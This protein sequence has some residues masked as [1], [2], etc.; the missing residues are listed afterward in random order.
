MVEAKGLARDRCSRRQVKGTH[1][2]LQ[3]GRLRDGVLHFGLRFNPE[4]SAFSPGTP[5]RCL[6]PSYHLSSDWNWLMIASETFNLRRVL[7]DLMVELP[8]MWVV[9][10]SGQDNVSRFEPRPTLAIGILRVEAWPRSVT[11]VRTAVSLDKIPIFTIRPM[12]HLS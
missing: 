2:L 12:V 9:R 8:G 7:I 6:R 11:P 1:L 3:A 4:Y 10:A 5:P